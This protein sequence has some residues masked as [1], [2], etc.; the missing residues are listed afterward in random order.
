MIWQI[1]AA[2]VLVPPLLYLL[3]KKRMLGAFVMSAILGLLTV[4]AVV[5]LSPLTGITLPVNALT[6]GTSV[7]LGPAGALGLALLRVV[8]QI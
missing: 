3:F 8:W 1:V 4:V 6:V 5:C 2:V 7:A